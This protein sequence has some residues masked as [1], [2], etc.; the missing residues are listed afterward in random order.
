MTDSFQTY[1]VSA[2]EQL[3]SSKQNNMIQAFEDAINSLDNSN[4]SGVAALAVSK[5]AAG[6][7]GDV[8]TTA[9]GVPVWGTP[10]SGATYQTTLPGS[11]VNGQLTYLVDSTTAPTYCWALRYNS[12][13]SSNKWDFIGGAPYTNEVATSQTTNSGSYVDLATVGPSFT[14]PVAGDYLVT[15][16]GHTSNQTSNNVRYATLNVGGATTDNN[17]LGLGPTA[18][19]VSGQFTTKLTALPASTLVK[20]QY[21]V[22]N[23]DTSTWLNRRLSVLPIAVGG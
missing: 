2:S 7:N 10:A 23:G 3:S 6:S 14:S 22:G 8:L 13:K 17:A 18:L 11:P 15:F 5:L 9:A 1:K 16:A 4:L 21:R 12:A 19:Q 20:V